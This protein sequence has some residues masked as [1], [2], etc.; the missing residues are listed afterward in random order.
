MNS[1]DVKKIASFDDIIEQHQLSRDAL[2]ALEKRLSQQ[3]NMDEFQFTSL[4]K[5]AFNKEGFW[6][7]DP[8]TDSQHV[9]VQGA[10]SS[11]KTLVSEMAIM[12]CLKSRKK[13]IVL[14][15]LK[16][17][18]R[19]RCESL[20]EDLKPLGTGQVYASSSDF[21]DHDGDIV[22]GDYEVA[23]IVYEKFFA[24]LTQASG[25]MMNDCALLVVDEMQMLS[26]I[27]RGPKLEISIQKI[28]RRNESS[29]KNTVE[30]RIMCLTTS[31]CKAN[32]IYK[33][34]TVRKNGMEQPPILISC[35]KRPVGLK[36]YVI[37]LDGKWRMRYTAGENIKDIDVKSE[38]EGALDVPGYVKECKMEQAKQALLKALLLKI[39]EDNP[40]AKVLV[41]ANG[42]NKT[43]KLAE[44]IAQLKLT[45]VKRLSD[46]AKEINNYDGDE[47]QNILKENLLPRSIAFHNA[48]LSVALREFIEQLY[49]QEGALCYVVA[50][51]TLT[52]GMN[53][54]VDV[55]ILY[56]TIVHRGGGTP[57]EALTSQE[58]K[59]FVGRAG[60]LGQTNRMGESY[61]FATSKTDADKYWDSYVNCRT[62]EIESALIYANE[63]EQAPYYLSLLGEEEYT[64]EDLEKL[65]NKSFSKCC[66][67]TSLNMDRVVREL[68]KA[69]LCQRAEESDDESDEDVYELSD[70]GRLMAP[71]AF[72][73]DT[74]KKI[75]KLFFDGGLRR[76]R[77]EKRVNGN[78][79][80]V[81][82][83]QTV[84]DPG[85]GGLPENVTQDDIKNDRYLLD[86]LYALCCTEEVRRM[87]QLKLP[88]AEK[89]PE[90]AR[91]ALDKVEM[92][93]KDMIAEKDEKPAKCEV[94]KASPLSYMLENGYVHEREEKESAMRAI[95]LWHWTKGKTM[96]EIK[97]ETGFNNFVSIVSGDLA[98]MAEVV[99]YQL[100][101]IYH[102]YGGYAGKSRFAPRALGPLYALSTRVKYGMRRDLVIIMNRQLRG[103]DRKTV[104]RIGAACD[105]LGKYDS[106]A[107]F[108][109]EAPAEELEGIITEQQRIE[110]LRRIDDL[111]LRD[112]LPSLL[113][114][115]QSDLGKMSL[116]DE[117]RNA[118]EQLYNI[119]GDTK[120]ENLLGPLD[121]IFL[122]ED[123]R[124]RLRMD[125]EIERP[126]YNERVNLQLFPDGSRAKLES[127]SGGDKTVFT[128]GI[129]TGN[130][131]QDENLSV[132]FA[133][134]KRRGINI[135]LFKQ[136]AALADIHQCRTDGSVWELLDEH[137]E[138]LIGSIH[139]AMTF[140]TF[141]ELIAQD[142]ALD[143]SDAHILLSMLKD[144]RGVFQMPGLQILRP[145]LQN[146]DTASDQQLSA[147]SAESVEEGASVLR[148]LYDR[149][150][151]R[152]E[153]VLEHITQKLKESHILYRVLRWG[154]VLDSEAL[155][156][157]PTMLFLE[158]DTVKSSRS[159][160]AFCNCLRRNH[161]RHTYALFN[162]EDAYRKWG[163]ENPKLPCVE[164]EHSC[165]TKDID[166]IVKKISVLSNL[167]KRNKY[168]IGVSYAK[169]KI[170]GGMRPA[171]AQLER[172]VELLN[173][174][175]G[176]SAVLFDENPSSANKFDG[177]GVLPEALKLYQKCD[178]FLI[179]DDSFYDLSSACAREG[180]VIFEKLHQGL[181]AGHLWFLHPDNDRHCS[182]FNEGRDYST[183]LNLTE[184]NSKR[185]A[186]Q[187]IEKINGD[188]VGEY[189]ERKIRV[190]INA[191][192]QDAA[193]EVSDK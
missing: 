152:V 33:W 21:Q 142:I 170:Q 128:I 159:L 23:V 28:L 66:S 109:K 52:I 125:S 80:T 41:F 177:N 140:R 12:D 167:F 37:Q 193:E 76:V 3:A 158:W 131:K 54:P 130:R 31:D 162:S 59:N 112:R 101:A 32:Y 120:E 126:I 150:L 93:L 25:N 149:R 134:E 180:R 106:P 183:R 182:L 1:S 189:K 5:E 78:T 42:R 192:R 181:A 176:E 103:I 65:W 104:L 151:D 191:D 187:I 136:E 87:G 30:T 113:D 148:I 2:K 102:C 155:T 9:I 88:V 175:Y 146:Y 46:T 114:T 40:K 16:A 39:H 48:A 168:L 178:Y 74:C 141:S 44:F 75:R 137:G 100:E 161:Y 60:R 86:I 127:E 4:Q 138:V 64:Q 90:K 82:E 139:I 71:Y 55:M 97:K 186:E 174:E 132:Y 156:D 123:A 95:L 160:D 50:T 11:G 185:V 110:L 61:V 69:K 116:G 73:L 111:Y 165:Q 56:D 17:M 89:N 173:E 157:A 115:I 179:L 144:I 145:F 26:S 133:Q 8:K 124:F 72:S 118:I 96:E 108:L 79:E 35:P 91:S 67:G 13:S 24:M 38:D 84:P 184:E 62:E 27:N 166:G 85:K 122:T 154:E 18:V 34:L 83:W 57:P 36:E 163:T 119:S 68:M 19:E 190:T 6:R 22:N 47:Y 29:R 7:G 117:A 135:L 20:Q 92:K 53:M 129:Y 164:L 58:Y 81:Y 43:K 49:K 45:E 10:T 171:V 147:E 51:E 94:W 15:P 70:Y 14:V 153:R 121:K 143:D 107:N 172:I 98:R 99:S 188:I 169:D 63:I 105:R 77:R